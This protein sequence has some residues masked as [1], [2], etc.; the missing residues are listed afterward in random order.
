M[1]T[2]TL[3]VSRD[4][5]SVALLNDALANGLLDTVTRTA[6]SRLATVTWRDVKRPV[7]TFSFFIWRY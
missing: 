2:P 5:D 7:S 3:N 1:Q 6:W 4:A